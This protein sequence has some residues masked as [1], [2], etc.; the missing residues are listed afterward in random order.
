MDEKEE[1]LLRVGF[2]VLQHN[3]P[4]KFVRMF[5]RSKI[6]GNKEDLNNFEM[7]YD[8]YKF[9]VELGRNLGG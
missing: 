7:D 9:L 4:A 3:D 6:P 2:D 1:I 5:V 8:D